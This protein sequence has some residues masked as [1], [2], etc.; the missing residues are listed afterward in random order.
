MGTVHK[1]EPR[2]GG[3]TYLALKQAIERESTESEDIDILV[4]VPSVERR[5]E[6]RRQLQC[7]VGMRSTRVQVITM[8]EF[9]GRQS[10]RV[11]SSVIL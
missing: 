3:K 4:I 10:R 5:T 6:M 8:Q 1:L 11:T 9:R 7:M 2:M